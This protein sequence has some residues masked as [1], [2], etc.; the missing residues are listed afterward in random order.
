MLLSCLQARGKFVFGFFFLL[1]FIFISSGVYFPDGAVHRVGLSCSRVPSGFSLGMIRK[2]NF[3][4]N[5]PSSEVDLKTF[6]TPS[7]LN[8][9]DGGIA[10]W[11]A[12]ALWLFPIRASLSCRV[13]PLFTNMDD[14]KP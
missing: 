11:H 5:S 1:F 2:A 4:T 12:S 14:F 13:S 10:D 6:D 9:F 3:P 7:K 8:G